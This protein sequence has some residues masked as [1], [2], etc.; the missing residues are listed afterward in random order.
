MEEAM[1]IPNP[2]KLPAQGYPNP[3]QRQEREQQ[4][5]IK[6]DGFLNMNGIHV[7]TFRYGGR[8]IP[9]PT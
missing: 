1:P 5:R 3:E 7:E 8:S 6:T 4:K 2:L 9:N